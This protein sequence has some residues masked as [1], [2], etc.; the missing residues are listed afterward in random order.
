ASSVLFPTDPEKFSMVPGSPFAYWVSDQL[1]Q[2]FVDLPSF[3]G[4]GRT[5]KQGLATADDFRFVRAW[6]EVNPAGVVGG[7]S[8][9]TPDEFR[10]Q[11]FT[12]KK[13]VPFAKGGDY[14]PYYADFHLLVNWDKDGK[15]IKDFKDPKSG[16]NY[17][18][19]QNTEYYFRPGLTWPLRASH[20]SPQILPKGCIFS[21]RSYCAFTPENEL[22]AALTI[23]GSSTFDYL[24]KM[25]LGRF[26]Y[27]EFIVG[28]LKK[29]PWPDFN[30]N[31][32]EIEVMSQKMWGHY[33]ELN[34]S[35][36]SIHTFYC[37]ILK[38]PEG[39]LSQEE[40]NNIILNEINQIQDLIDQT[41]FSF[42]DISIEDIA[43]VVDSS[44]NRPSPENIGSTGPSSFSENLVSYMAGCVF[45]RWDILYATGE[46]ETP[47]LPDPIAPLP[48]CPPGM[49]LGDDCLPLELQEI[50]EDYPLAV[51]ADGILVDD[52]GHSDDII[53]RIRDVLTVIWSD[54]ADVIEK[55]A[56]DIL[57]VKSLRDY[58][59]KPA[60]GGFWDEHVKRY[61]KSRRKAPIYWLLQSAKKN[62]AI[63]IY[64]PRM[65]GDTLYKALGYAKDKL[66]MEERRLEDLQGEREQLGTGGAA[67]KRLEKE[68]DGQEAFISELHDFVEKLERAANLDLIPEHD[69]GVVL[70]IAPLWE[71]VPWREPKNY[72]DELIEGKY[73][74]SSIGKQLA[75]KG[76]VRRS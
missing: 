45:G 56:C 12:G 36:E 1:R 24:F 18:R 43:S 5:V 59:R 23:F 34:R 74:W 6:W 53:A 75:E 2:L 21:V 42:Y 51:D 44:E 33:A 67:V 76:M 17:S 62:Y 66:A 10:A 38:N 8:E 61:S 19:P 39:D 7:T 22:N 11:T 71:L 73:E 47:E 48:A 65:D 69:D 57:G 60:T 14:S 64:Y 13:W 3:E 55:E 26:G 31:L 54:R 29:M 27:P 20:F 49:L 63:W 30:Q 46:K 32:S 41:G 9:T 58:F 35:D 52:E 15:E 16:K 25:M 37:P 68:I 72:W 70:T 50:P 4:N 28:I 40:S